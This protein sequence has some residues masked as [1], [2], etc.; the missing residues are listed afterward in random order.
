M[1]TH[2]AL[3]VSTFRFKACIL[4]FPQE[5]LLV[6]FDS[7]SSV[8]SLMQSCSHND[9]AKVIPTVSPFLWL[10]ALPSAAGSN[11]QD[12]S[13]PQITSDD[14]CEKQDLHQLLLDAKSVIH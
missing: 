14:A 2:F 8:T 3:F 6:E 1:H 7:D 10:R 9:N 5:L 13:L 11:C 4:F 12:Q